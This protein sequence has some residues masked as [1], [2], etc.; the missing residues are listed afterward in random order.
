MN[1]ANTSFPGPAKEAEGD[2]GAPLA[3]NGPSALLPPPH[4]NPKC[5]AKSLTQWTSL[6]ENHTTYLYVEGSFMHTGRKCVP[7]IMSKMVIN[8]C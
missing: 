6:P 3:D 8:I 7:P 4:S 1:Q 2:M 5:S